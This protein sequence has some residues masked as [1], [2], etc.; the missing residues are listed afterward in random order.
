[1]ISDVPTQEATL[2][3]ILAASGIRYFSSGINN[4][5]AYTFT[6]MQE[7]CPCW[8]EGPDGSRVLMMYMYGYA[9]ASGWGLDQ[10]VEAARPNV[11]AQL[12]RYADRKNYPFD[13]V[14]LHGAV[15]DNC[16][17][18]SQ[19]AEVGKA[20]NQRYEYPKIIFSPN[21]AFFEYIE[22][23]YGE[24]LPVFR[25]SAGTYWEDGAGSSARDGHGPPRARANRSG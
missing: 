6:Q 4:D 11:L 1:M 10:S 23:H 20:W 22:K 17:L 24:A 25:G 13:A 16:A 8:W 2:P 7:K 19:L 21:A 14:F 9:Q 3:M 5:R 12:Q 18:N 15:S